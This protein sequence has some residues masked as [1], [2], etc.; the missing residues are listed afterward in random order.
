[1]NTHEIKAMLNAKRDTLSA[2]RQIARDEIALEKHSEE[3]DEIQQSATRTLALDALTRQWEM[4]N[5]IS[6][7][8]ERIEHSTFGICVECE[9]EISE[10]RL[11]AIPWA[12]YCIHCQELRDHS[13]ADPG[14][15]EVALRPR[16]A[17]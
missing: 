1:M 12:K 8:L 6:E 13:T 11:R 9:E 16:F 5:L 17:D 3:M 10:K 7:A 2:A 4:A 14:Y 15:A